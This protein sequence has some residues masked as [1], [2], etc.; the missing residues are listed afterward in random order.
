MSETIEQYKGFEIQRVRTFTH[1]KFKAVYDG[2]V[3]HSRYLP[4]SIPNGDKERE[5]IGKLKS[6]IDEYGVPEHF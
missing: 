3:A 6:D 5:I 4:L 1:I 2:K